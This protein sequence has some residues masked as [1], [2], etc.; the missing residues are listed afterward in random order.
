MRMP[1]HAVLGADPRLIQ[2]AELRPGLARRVWSFAGPYK[3]LI[4][5]FICAIVVAAV[6]KLVPPLLAR[7]LIDDVLPD[8]DRDRLW[9]VVSLVV[10]AG[11]TEAGLSLI[12]RWCSARIGEGLI[13]DLRVG[14]FDHVQ[15]MPM[16][17]FTRSQTG[18]LVS[19]LNNDVIGAQRALTT[20]L[21]SVVSNFFV[22]ATTLGAMA[23]LEWRLT[24]LALSLLPLF[25]LPTRKVGRHLQGLTRQSMQFNAEMNTTMTERFNVAGALLVKLF[26]RHDN[27]VDRF[28]EKAAGV[29]DMGVRSAVFARTFAIALGL[30]ASLGV[31]VVYL[32]GGSMVIDGSISIGTLVAMTALVTR[33]YTPL[34][35]LSNARVDIM[36]ALVSFDRVFEVLDTHVAITDRPGA[37]DLIEPTGRVEFDHVGFTYPTESQIESLEVKPTGESGGTALTEDDRGISQDPESTDPA[38]VLD[39][40]NLCVE[41]GQMLALVGPSGAGKSS[42]VSLIPRLYDVSTGAVRVDGRDVRDITQASLRASVGMVAQDPHLFHDTVANNLRYGRPDA[43]KE[44]LADACRSAR[45]HEVIAN[46]PEGYDTIVGERG[47][48]LSGGEKQRLAIARMLLKDPAIVIL[49]EATSHL[50]AENEVL[51]QQALAEALKGRTALVIAHRLSTITSADRI[52]V[53]DRGRV[54]ESGT[55]DEL[56]SREGLYADLHSVMRTRQLAGQP[57]RSPGRSSLPED[58]ETW[59]ASEEGVLNG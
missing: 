24:L 29:R 15:R 28:A 17:F 32:V 4:A 39:D 53:L 3:R 49:D 36:T 2:G 48:R 44:D 58:M 52:V 31:A 51:V 21:G 47:Y 38:I 11:V 34:T 12:E 10:A 13:F 25:L 35:G 45:I 23:V 1:P 50:D 57:A 54:V 19:R 6:V 30:V 26:G 16:A 33:I 14:L 20:T 7:T 42:L 27:E 5:L 56:L 22:L 40:I 55:H 43:T 59:P 46:L 41:P 8:R 18:A 9:L 37:V